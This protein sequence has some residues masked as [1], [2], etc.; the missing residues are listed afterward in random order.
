[1]GGGAA[2][3]VEIGNRFATRTD[4]DVALASAP[5][6]TTRVRYRPAA[7]GRPALEGRVLDQAT[8]EPAIGATISVVV[9]GDHATEI[10]D[11]DGRFAFATLAPGRWQLTTYFGEREVEVPI[12]VPRGWSVMIEQRID[13][14]IPPGDV[15]ELAPGP[16]THGPAMP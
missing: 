6:P 9:P 4:A 14:S 15:I 16:R 11:E 3:R 1:M 2:A 7:P 13:T 10:T 5:S 12:H 8:G